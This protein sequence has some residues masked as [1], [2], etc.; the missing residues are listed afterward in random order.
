MPA[1]LTRRGGEPWRAFDAVWF[2][3]WQW[4]LLLIL[5][6]P[7]LGRVARWVLR[8]RRTEIGHRH[9]IVKIEPHAYHVQRPAAPRRQRVLFAGFRPRTVEEP[10][11]E[12]VTCIRTSPKFAKRVY[13]A[14]APVWWALHLWDWAIADRWVPAMSAGF[15]T[16]TAYPDPSPETATCDGHVQRG[17]V[18]ETFTTIRNGAGVQTADNQATGNVELQ[19]TSTSNQFS[20]LFRLFFGFD[21]SS[22]AGATVAAAALFLTPHA[23][24]GMDNGLGGG[25]TYHITAAAPAS[26]TALSTSDYGNVSDTS[27]ASQAGS[28]LSNGVE[29]EW[30]FNSSGIAAINTSGVS[31]FAARFGWDVADSFTGTWT[32]SGRARMVVYLADQTGNT[33]DPRLEVVYGLP[34]ISTTT[35]APGQVGQAYSETLLV[36]GGEGPFV[37][38]VAS[39]TVPTGLALGTP[40]GATVPLSGMPTSAPGTYNFTIQVEGAGGVTDDQAFTLEILPR[41]PT[42]RLPT[43]A[44]LRVEAYREGQWQVLSPHVLR[45]TSLTIGYGIRGGGP[46]DLLAGPGSASF[47]LNNWDE[48]GQYTPGHAHQVADWS[49]E[50]RVRISFQPEIAVLTPA[51]FPLLTS[52]G[53]AVQV[54]PTPKFLGRV[55]WIDP[56]AGKYGPRRV[57]VRVGDYMAGMASEEV[58]TIAVQ[59]GQSERALLQAIFAAI[60]SDVR[61]PVRRLDEGIDTYPYALDD[62]G[63]GASPGGLFTDVLESAFATLVQYGNGDVVSLNRNTRTYQ[64]SQVTLTEDE[65]EFLDAPTDKARLYRRVIVEIPQFRVGAVQEVLWAE[66]G[67]DAVGIEPGGIRDFWATYRDPDAEANQTQGIAGY[68]T[69]VDPFSTTAVFNAQSDGGGADLSGAVTVEAEYYA[70]SVHYRLT[71]TGGSTAHRITL[72]TNALPIR[73]LKPI[74]VESVSAQGRGAT[75]RIALRYQVSRTIAQFIADYVR[76]QW[77]VEGNRPRRVAFDPQREERLMRTMLNREPGNRVTLRESVSATDGDSIIQGLEISSTDGEYW[78]CTW[79]VA[80]VASYAFITPMRLGEA[81]QMEL[82][83]TTVLG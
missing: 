31:Q 10:A 73:R 46:R 43:R 40:V 48:V 68:A 83:E 1:P 67:V 82:G 24:F 28:G 64:A 60:P 45:E 17:G 29:A 80:P 9:R 69:D 77:E 63:S 74:E 72:E 70:N 19:A 49:T 16:L 54:G 42:D 13:R 58:R 5:D 81:G 55:T 23:S 33:E 61:P 22:L 47:G 52:S 37:W 78:R 25:A 41:A 15:A 53:T 12:R 57:H 30:A 7:I 39:G 11:L 59:I 8:I 56:E 71:N 65:L 62:G 14:F 2:R 6:E 4:L 34:T 38:S 27:F 18:N 36:E 3:R 35:L 50:T 75:L 26:P 76:S 21:T 20:N 51:G 66:E 44:S 32:S 79:L